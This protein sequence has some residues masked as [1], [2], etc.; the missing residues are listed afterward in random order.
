[1]GEINLNLA[2]LS[3]KEGKMP[4]AVRYY[5]NA[6]FGTWQPDQMASQPAKVRTELVEFLLG[7]GYTSQALS[8]LLILSADIPDTEEAHNEVGHLL[9]AAGDSQHALDHFSRVLR[10]NGKN[11]DAL[12]GAG[13]A[14]FNLAEYSKARRLLE[15]AVTNGNDSPN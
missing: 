8:E 11:A 9:L 6:L 3:A 15:A 13:H 4:D 10:L 7:R 5:H 2:R 14:N 1:N 12:S